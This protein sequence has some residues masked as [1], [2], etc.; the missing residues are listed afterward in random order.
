MQC[1]LE[2]FEHRYKPK[3][4]LSLKHIH[5][6]LKFILENSYFTLVTNSTCKYMGTLLAPN[7]ANIFMTKMENQILHN[8]EHYKTPLLWKRFIDDIFIIWP[9]SEI[10]QL[11]FLDHINTM[12]PT[13]KFEM[14]Y[15][16][17]K[18][19]FLDTAL[20]LQYS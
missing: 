5:Q 11:Q 7:Y 14:E 9:H 18:V 16:Q 12:N 15:L 19:N 3:T 8:L 10:E 6:R 2:A 17:S 1:C 20:I 13:I 4:P